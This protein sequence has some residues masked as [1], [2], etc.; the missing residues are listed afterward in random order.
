MLLKLCMASCWILLGWSVAYAFAGSLAAILP[1]GLAVTASGAAYAGWLAYKYS[2]EKKEIAQ[3]LTDV[4]YEESRLMERLRKAEEDRARQQEIMKAAA[5]VDAAT[6]LPNEQLYKL[7]LD[8]AWA[9]CRRGNKPIALVSVR[10]DMF[11]ELVETKGHERAAECLAKVG[12]VLNYSCRRPM[13][14]CAHL[15]GASF[16]IVLPDTDMKGAQV[17]ATNVRGELAKSGILNPRSIVGIY[18]TLSMGLATAHP[19]TDSLRLHLE[20]VAAENLE[21]ALKQ[22]GSG[23]YPPLED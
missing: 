11:E 15:G 14:V 21:Q 7:L 18:V 10:V 19:L 12:Q 6:G 23:C 22:G 3:Q 20:N 13:D 9:H 5:A 8:K 1:Y 2:S 4:L 16:S 17:V